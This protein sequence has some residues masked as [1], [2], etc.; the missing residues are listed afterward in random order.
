MILGITPTVDYAFKHLFGRETTR[1]ILINVMD[2]VLQPTPEHRI[3]DVNLFNPKETLDDKL[4]ILDIKARDQSGRQFNIEMQMVAYRYYEKRILYYGC[5]LHQQQLHEG[6]NY[7]KLQPTISISFLDHVLFPNVPDYHLRFRLLEETHSF[8]FTG[9]LE[10]HI[11]EL[12]KF[13]KSAA[14]LVT[15]LDIWLYFLRHAE[16]MD[17]DALPA[18]LK[19]HPLVVRA[20]EELKM[21]AQTDQERERYEARR[22]AQLDYNTGLL[23]ARLEGQEA[24]LAKGR[25]EGREQGRIEGMIDTIHR[26]ERLLQRSETPTGGLARLTLD[27]LRRLIDELQV[28]LLPQ[29]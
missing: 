16:K 3:S 28:K 26:F 18:A 8:P 12:P 4:S 6:D 19:Q 13:T 21:L 24:G 5:R 14:E 11:L 9:D 20:M 22:K 2:S 1:P 23:V 7:L 27:E 10:F 17:T 29:H 15:E 25:E